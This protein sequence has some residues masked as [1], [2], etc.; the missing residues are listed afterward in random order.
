MI[1][2]WET[3]SYQWIVAE[4]LHSNEEFANPTC[5]SCNTLV[6]VACVFD[7]NRFGGKKNVLQ[8]DALS[9]VHLI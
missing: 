6:C 5:S 8:N 9:N 2:S 3:L 4:V 7:S 1:L